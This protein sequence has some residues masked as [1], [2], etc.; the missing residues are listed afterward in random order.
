MKKLLLLPIL[1]L[2]FSYVSC[3]REGTDSLSI[4]VDRASNRLTLI[5]DNKEMKS[6][7]VITDSGT[8]VGNVKIVNK[9]K[10]PKQWTLEDGLL[11]S[12]DPDNTL[13]SR[14]I[15]FDEP[16]Y[17]INGDYELNIKKG[18]TGG[19]IVMKDKDIE[20]LYDIVPIGTEVIIK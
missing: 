4:I 10:D 3:V 16:G 18:E 7:S 14:W 9:I 2:M 19:C 6:Y 13:G 17:G 11:Q 5:I 15:G 8:P 20:E 1:I 12:G